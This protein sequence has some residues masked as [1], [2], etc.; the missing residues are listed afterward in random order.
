VPALYFV[1]HA[2]AGSRSHWTGDD[3][4]RPLSKK[5]LKQAEALVEVLE[6]FSITSIYSSPYLRC[7]QTV[8]PLARA[9]DLDLNKTPALAEGAGLKGAMKLVDDLDLGDAVLSTHGDVVWELV[10][11]LVRRRIIPASERG[12]DKGSTWV[13]DIEGGVPRSARFIP[14]P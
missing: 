6:P 4:L 2:K 11:D 7:V 10:E 9:G 8:E 14:A 3:R 13:V 5:G 12:F 1:R